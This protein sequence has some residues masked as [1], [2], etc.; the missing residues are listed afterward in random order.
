MTDAEVDLLIKYRDNFALRKQL[1][2]KK[3]VGHRRSIKDRSTY[4]HNYNFRLN[5]EAAKQLLNIDAALTNLSGTE[6]TIFRS[7]M[8]SAT[9]L[10]VAE[11]LLKHGLDAKYLAYFE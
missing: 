5:P 6:A 10:G 4:K 2:D 7:M 9:D 11:Q 3:F 8:Q 1:V